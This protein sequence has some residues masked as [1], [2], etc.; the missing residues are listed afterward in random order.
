MP[1]RCSS[2]CAHL[3]RPRLGAEH[4]DLER[5]RARVDA[6]LHHRV[7]DREQV[8]RRAEDRVGLEVAD[9]LH[10]ARGLAAR[11]RDDRGAERLDAG[12]RAEPAGEQAVAVG[13]VHLHAGADAAGPQRA[14][15]ERRPALEVA[16][17]VAD[18]GRAAGRAARRVDAGDLLHRHGEHAERVGLAQVGLRRERQLRDI[19]QRAD[20]VGVHAR[21]VELARVERHVR[22]GVPHGLLQPLELERLD[23]G[24]GHPL[25]G[26]EVVAGAGARPETMVGRWSSSTRGAPR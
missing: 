22:V 21:L 7:G 9:E 5:G 18:D 3:V 11:H 10:L 24:A 6:R 20:V 26:V 2:S 13:V 15:D 1:R 16:L 23:L 4:G 17:R 19:R 8:A 14:G 25:L 12:V